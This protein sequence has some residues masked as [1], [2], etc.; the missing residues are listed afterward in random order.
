MT[1]PDGSSVKPEREFIICEACE[2]ADGDYDK[3]GNF[4]ICE[5]C[6]GGGGWWRDVG[7]QPEPPK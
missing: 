6:E 7:P 5:W 2:G 1:N 3:E 4:I